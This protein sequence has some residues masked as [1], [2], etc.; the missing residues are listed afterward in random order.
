[1][2]FKVLANPDHSMVR[3]L[4]ARE[5]AGLLRDRPGCPPK[6]LASEYHLPNSEAQQIR[7]C[8]HEREALRAPWQSKRWVVESWTILSVTKY[9]HGH[10]LL[11]LRRRHREK[12][13]KIKKPNSSTLEMF[14]Y[15]LLVQ[16]GRAERSRRSKIREGK[17]VER[18]RVGWHAIRSNPDPYRCL[19]KL[20]EHDHALN[21]AGEDGAVLPAG[22]ASQHAGE[23]WSPGQELALPAD[24]SLPREHREETG[25]HS[26]AENLMKAGTSQRRPGGGSRLCTLLVPL[27]RKTAGSKETTLKAEKAARLFAALS[28]P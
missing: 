8:S 3:I 22:S 2:I 1:M 7:V 24:R 10:I 18:T 16:S 27:H 11:C 17:A 5:A 13:D 12:D 26:P 25:N 4:G 28:I 21:A 19:G 6:P 20:D 15:L 23:L 9:T 14:S